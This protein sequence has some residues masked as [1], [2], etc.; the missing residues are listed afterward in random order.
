MAVRRPLVSHLISLVRIAI[1]SKIEL[2]ITNWLKSVCR[3]LKARMRAR[4]YWTLNFTREMPVK[5]SLS[6]MEVV[7][8][9]PLR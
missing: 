2:E 6:I 4:H 9:L 3:R 8:K 1:G 7:K 5:I